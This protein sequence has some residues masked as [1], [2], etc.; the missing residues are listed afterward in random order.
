MFVCALAHIGLRLRALVRPAALV[1]NCLVGRLARESHFEEGPGLV[2]GKQSD[3][4]VVRQR[5][6]F[7]NV[8]TE[9][10]AAGVALPS[11]VRSA[12]QRI[13]DG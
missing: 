10:K 6:L 12:V 11:G 9:T 5:Y 1:L 2:A 4:P 7:C 13:E 8:E 3:N